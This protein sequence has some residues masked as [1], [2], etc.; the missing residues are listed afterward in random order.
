MDE[1]DGVRWK[2]CVELLGVVFR[3]LVGRVGF[4]Y[5]LKNYKR[6]GVYGEYGIFV[7]KIVC[8]VFWVMYRYG[9]WY[10]YFIFVFLLEIVLWGRFSFGGGVSG[11]CL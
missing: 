5:G 1:Y 8:W 9:N 2:F 3:S 7:M 6:F 11:W 10:I 4:F